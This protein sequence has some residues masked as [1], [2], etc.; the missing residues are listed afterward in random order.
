MR[1]K[2]ISD[3]VL[4]KRPFSVLIDESTSLGKNSCLII[5]IR[6][7]VGESSE[8]QS[9]MLDIIDL[10]DTTAAGILDALLECLNKRGLT[11]TVLAHF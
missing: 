2:L 9:F 10:K 5:Y 8:P 1:K 6:S 4:Q 7:C 11:D 3:I